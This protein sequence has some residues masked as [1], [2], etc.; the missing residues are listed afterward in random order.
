MYSF[1]ISVEDSKVPNRFVKL[2][3]C[4]YT[5]E[6]RMH[7][8]HVALTMVA[9]AWFDVQTASLS[10]Y[11]DCASSYEDRLEVTVDSMAQLL[12]DSMRGTNPNLR[13]HYPT[14]LGFS[15]FQ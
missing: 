5:T 11:R 2:I 1:I 7:I 12:F 3:L 8:H 13:K 6:E 10:S 15:I 4:L 14:L 9:Y